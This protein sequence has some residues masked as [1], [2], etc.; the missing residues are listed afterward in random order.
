MAET[1]VKYLT[2]PIAEVRDDPP[3]LGSGMTREGYTKTSG[4]P[5]DRMIR[6][7]G[8]KTWRRL[9]VWQ[10]SNL[11]TMF[12]R[13]KGE[14]LVVREEDIPR[15]TAQDQFDRLSDDERVAIDLIQQGVTDYDGRLRK[16]VTSEARRRQLRLLVT[17]LGLAARHHSSVKRGKRS[18]QI[19]YWNGEPMYVLG[20]CRRVDEGIVGHDLRVRPLRLG[21]G[22]YT[23]VVSPDDVREKP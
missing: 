14:P 9:M 3:R 13:I 21:K 6:L 7:E 20:T 22:P 2:T 10:F 15:S 23:M 18:P 4:A 11:G 16:L 5:T 8:E 19:A 1:I 12:V 17:R